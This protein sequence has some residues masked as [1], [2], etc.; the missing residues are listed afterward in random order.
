MMV[1][2]PLFLIPTF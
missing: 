1:I 2:R